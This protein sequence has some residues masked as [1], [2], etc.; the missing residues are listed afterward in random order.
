MLKP[1]LKPPISYRQQ[2][3]RLKSCGLIIDSP[4]QAEMFLRHVSYYRF[5]AYRIPFQQKWDGTTF[6]QIQRLYELDEALREAFSIA[7]SAVEIF[8]R[9]HIT[10]EL[11][12]T[13]GAFAHYDPALFRD[14][15]W[16]KEWLKV[17]EI[18]IDRRT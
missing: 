13:Y 15:L 8:L 6:A 10:H 17:L 7:V 5:S 11:T 1:Y 3:E 18:E 9:T 2:V 14:I 12:M 16:Q 4:A